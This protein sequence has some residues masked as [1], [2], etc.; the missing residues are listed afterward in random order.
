MHNCSI[1]TNIPKTVIEIIY[2]ILIEDINSKNNKVTR[3]TCTLTVTV[4]SAFKHLR[5]E[6]N[7]I[8]E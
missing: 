1:N 2:N 5:N 3:C 6:R 7:S 8:S 4:N